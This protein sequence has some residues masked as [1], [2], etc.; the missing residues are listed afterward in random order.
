MTDKSMEELERNARRAVRLRGPAE[1]AHDPVLDCID[2]LN[3]ALSAAE[4]RA[5]EAEE[6]LRGLRRHCVDRGSNR[7]LCGDGR[8]MASPMCEACSRLTEAQSEALRLVGLDLEQ[9]AAAFLADRSDDGTKLRAALLARQAAEGPDPSALTADLC[10]TVA[11]LRASRDEYAAAVEELREAAKEVTGDLD[12]NE[13]G[14]AGHCERSI[15]GAENEWRD[16]CG[17][18]A[19]CRLAALLSTPTLGVIERVRA[20]ALREAADAMDASDRLALGCFGN[21]E[22]IDACVFFL[23][24]RADSLAATKGGGT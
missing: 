24:S 11:S 9:A 18:C 19:T 15:R 7:P 3:S 6:K 1:S 10:G 21:G 20:E 22:V 8:F 17:K 14:A 12:P 13:R 16:A 2:A 4:R 5:E 23:R